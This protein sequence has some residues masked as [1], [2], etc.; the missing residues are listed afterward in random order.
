MSGRSVT[1][2]RTYRSA[3]SIAWAAAVFGLPMAACLLWIGK[4]FMSGQASAF[5]LH[6]LDVGLVGALA[7]MTYRSVRLGVV[8]GD[9]D[10]VVRGFFSSRHVSYGDVVSV[11]VID[12]LGPWWIPSSKVKS[13][14]LDLVGGKKINI[15]GLSGG[16]QS[17]KQTR[18]DLEDAIGASVA[19][20]LS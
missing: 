5:V 14:R 16:E 20:T 1:R 9:S 6:P 17:M 19:R 8:L 18:D 3:H 7:T 15:W 2:A 11:S 13:L 4:P 12:Y 10:L